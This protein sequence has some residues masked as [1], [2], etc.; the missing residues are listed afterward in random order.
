MRAV[1]LK[2]AG[3]FFLIVGVGLAADLLTKMR[4]FDWLG[5]PPNGRTEW[6]W[7]G[8]FGFQTSLNEGALFGFG[9]GFVPVFAG[10]SIL[11][12]LGIFIWLFVGGALKDR[13]LTVA[14]AC[15]MAG[16]CGN[17]YD[18]LGWHGLTYPLPCGNHLTGDTVHAVRDFIL[19]M[20][21]PW[22]WPNFNLADSMLVC[23]AVLLIALSFWKKKEVL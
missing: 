23:G 2:H 9:Q 17:L 20:I 11:A 19:V 21:G 7:K 3:V 16:L 14:L 6:I 1:P 13:W 18:R 5:I 4:V 10:L 12:A 22:Q 15:I 8:F